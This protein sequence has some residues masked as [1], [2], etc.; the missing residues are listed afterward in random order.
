MVRK[1]IETLNALLADNYQRDNINTLDISPSITSD[2][3]INKIDTKELLYFLDRA[4]RDEWNH[5]L[6]KR[7]QVLVQWQESWQQQQDRYPL[8]Q[9]HVKIAQQ[10]KQQAMQKWK[11]SIQLCHESECEYKS[12]EQNL[13]QQMVQLLEYCPRE[14]VLSTQT[15]QPEHSFE[16]LEEINL[17]ALSQQIKTQ[18]QAKQTN[19]EQAQTEWNQVLQEQNWQQ[20]E[21]QRLQA[22]LNEIERSRA[23]SQKQWL[24]KLAEL[25]F[26]DDEDFLAAQLSD[27][28]EQQQLTEE[29]EAEYQKLQGL[30]QETRQQLANI[31]PE[32]EATIKE[33]HQRLLAIYSPT[34]QEQLY[35]QILKEITQ[36]DNKIQQVKMDMQSTSE[37]LGACKKSLEEDDKL[38]KAQEQIAE[39]LIQQQQTLENWQQLNE[40]IGSAN[41]DK[42]NRFA[43]Q[44]SF[45]QLL[46]YANQYLEKINDRY[47]L[48]SLNEQPLEFF[49]IDLYQQ[50]ALRPS[51]NLSGGE[52]FLISL[53]LA[54]ALA[55]IS[56]NKILVQSLFLDEGFGTLDEEAL[57]NTLEVLA[58]LREDGKLIGLISHIPALK[59]RIMCQIQLRNLGEGRSMIYCPSISGI[60]KKLN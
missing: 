29:W 38:Q 3:I 24:Q 39:Q 16:H 12:I 34:H 31:N 46:Y 19:R 40:L 56:S 33:Q 43:Q 54:L 6:E 10:Q 2:T 59:E 20:K 5:L 49:V 58:S 42:Y 47:V 51:S 41:G 11:D 7:H 4:Q 21:I 30:L 28:P 35:N 8:C 25:G 55:R 27:E 44:L 48:Q 23:K 32:I 26:T 52:K 37:E 50:Q 45:E 17:R 57:H 53:A 1:L 18:V 9:E 36:I 13:Q 15:I 14:D 60:V 22:E